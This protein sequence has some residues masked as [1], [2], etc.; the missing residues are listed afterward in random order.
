MKN[1]F[2]PFVFA[3]YRKQTP[4]GCNLHSGGAVRARNLGRVRG[5][6]GV[7]ECLQDFVVLCGNV[8]QE[9]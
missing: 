9:K 6:G 8:T 1:P 3:L 5:R 4:S 7:D 2:Q